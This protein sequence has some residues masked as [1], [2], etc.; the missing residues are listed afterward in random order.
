MFIY[1]ILN[2][3]N[4]KSYVG[5]SSKRSFNERYRAGKWWSRTHN[6]YLKRCARKHGKEAFSIIIL[7]DDIKDIDSLR[8]REQFWIKEKNCLHPNGYN[9]PFPEEFFIDGRTYFIKNVKTGSVVRVKNMTEFCESNGF[10]CSAMFSM[11]SGKN[12]Q[13]FGFCLPNTDISTLDSRLSSPKLFENIHT[14]EKVYITNY[15]TFC[16]KHQLRYSSLH[17]VAQGNVGRKSYKGWKLAET[18]LKEK[19]KYKDI[20]IVDPEGNEVF[21]KKLREF[22]LKNNLCYE[23]MADVVREKRF[24]HKGWKLLKNK[25]QKHK[26]KTKKLNFLLD[27]EGNEIIIDNIKEFCQQNNLSP[28]VLRRLILGERKSYNGYSKKE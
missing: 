10:G 27:K 2:N 1:Q 16:K 6:K 28:W 11:L 14:G 13:S 22:C 25:N 24:H 4:G 3:V 21:V 19:V 15:K 18:T 23:G 9:F 26:R 5:M 12:K 8:E 20:I 17:R 7:E